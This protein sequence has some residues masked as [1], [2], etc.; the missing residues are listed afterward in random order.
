MSKERI[1]TVEWIAK[2]KK[3]T[4]SRIKYTGNKLIVKN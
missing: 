2:G 3:T 1:F 4:V